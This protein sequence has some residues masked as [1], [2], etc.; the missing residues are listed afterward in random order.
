M[1]VKSIA[2]IGAGA[3]GR[4]IAY[5]AIAG[6]YQVTFEDISQERLIE[7]V[8]LIKQTLEGEASCGKL[9]LTARNTRM[10]LLGTARN[11][12]EAIRGADLIIETVPDELE[13]KLE[14]F[15]IF[16]RFAKPD[17]ILAS[18]THSFSVSDMSDVTVCRDRCIG[19]H[20]FHPVPKM[21]MIELVKTRF[22]SE[23]TVATC[24]EV[25][26]RMGKEVVVVNESQEK[27]PATK[28]DA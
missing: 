4:D 26:R 6:E 19:M 24:R 7:G 11:F 5:A 17:A 20:F 23:E 8:A 21:R 2:V 16:D 27:K 3:M 13:M 28:R 9:D 25:A 12:E 15:T 22:T 10:L 1:E 14:L 18:T